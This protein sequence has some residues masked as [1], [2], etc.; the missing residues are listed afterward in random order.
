MQCYKCHGVKKQESELR[1]DTYQALIKGGATGPAIVPNE[2]DQGLL[3]H[4]IEYD[5]EELQMPPK[6]R[7][8]EQVIK[9][10]KHWI[11]IGAP[12][13]D[14]NKRPTMPADPQLSLSGLEV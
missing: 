12:H 9:D 11:K 2:P 6:R 14:A 8:A 4:A 10:F 13:P 5:D 7:L 3:I 1:L